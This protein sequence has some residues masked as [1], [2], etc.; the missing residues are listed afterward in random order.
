MCRANFVLVFKILAP[1]ER[2]PGTQLR[3]LR[4]PRTFRD[5]VETHSRI[6]FAI[7][8]QQSQSSEILVL[9]EARDNPCI[10]EEE[11][12]GG[13]AMGGGAY[14]SSTVTHSECKPPTNGTTP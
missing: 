12:Q 10:Q 6:P 1:R 9:Q 5:I 11:S 8:R 14:S 7:C 4:T 13:S 3:K 2:G